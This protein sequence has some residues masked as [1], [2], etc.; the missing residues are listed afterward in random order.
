MRQR[1]L[2]T[3][4]ILFNTNSSFCS[5]VATVWY[6]E[7]AL[8]LAF[9]EPQ[10][11]KATVPHEAAPATGETTREEGTNSFESARPSSMFAS[12]VGPGPSFHLIC[13]LSKYNSPVV[14]G[15]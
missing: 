7:H 11:S 15:D 12:E 13:G 8:L 1:G 5:N 10:R 6:S 2:A 14:S 9:Q 3:A 4:C